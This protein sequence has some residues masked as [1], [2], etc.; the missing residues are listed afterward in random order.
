MAGVFASIS[1]FLILAVN[2][3]AA[4]AVMFWLLASLAP[5]QWAFLGLPAGVVLFGTCWPS[6]QA[7]LLN[8]LVIGDD[9]ATTLGED[10]RRLR[11]SLITVASLTTGV[12][13]A[14]SGTIGFVG[15][16]IPHLAR[17][18]AAELRIG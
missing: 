6:L 11:R 7:R 1:S 10:V 18:A 3:K 14:V 16:M 15:L 2:R 8:A 4:R 9:T 12:L 13:V 17:L 5:A